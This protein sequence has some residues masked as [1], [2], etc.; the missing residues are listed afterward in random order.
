MPG[1]NGRWQ[2]HE[3][4]ADGS[5]LREV[6]LIH[7]SD[8]DNYDACYLPD[9][10]IIFTSTAPFIGVPCV[11]GAAHVT[12]LYRR[13]PAGEIRRLTVDQ[14]HDW[15]PAVLHEGRVLYQRWE[16]TDTPHAFYRLLFTMNPDGTAQ[17][18]LYGSNSYWPNAMFYARPVP[19]HPS[20]VV[21]VVGGHHDHP[22]MG[23][24]V[25]FDPGRGRFEAQG[26]VQRIPGRG[27]KVEPILRDGLTADSWPK[28]LHPFPLSEKHFLVSCR[29][30]PA[31]PWGIYLADVFDNLLLLREEPGYAL[32]E[33]VPLRKTGSPFLSVT[34]NRA[35]TRVS[36]LVF[37][38]KR[39]DESLEKL[40]RF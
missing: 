39:A 34:T 12:N 37:Q 19:G 17:S 1:S 30:S 23:E 38:G 36:T 31:A 18:A 24:L 5:G 27:K 35:R 25:V 22:R 15:C 3:L 40:G 4:N 7:E 21:A 16:Y 29:P 10:A 2:V 26:A 9:G 28:F 13:E 14:E 6:P 11:R 8:V 20:K 32:L 33:P